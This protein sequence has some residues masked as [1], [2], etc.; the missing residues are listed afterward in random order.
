MEENRASVPTTV[1]LAQILSRGT[2]KGESH[3]SKGTVGPS[4]PIQLAPEDEWAAARR[5]DLFLLLSPPEWKQTVDWRGHKNSRENTNKFLCWLM[6]ASTEIKWKSIPT[7]W[8]PTHLSRSLYHRRILWLLVGVHSSTNIYQAPTIWQALLHMLE[9]H[10]LWRGRQD[11]LA[12]HN[13][14][15]RF[16]WNG[17]PLLEWH[18]GVNKYIDSYMWRNGYIK[19]IAV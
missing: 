13:K 11:I 6:L 9:I 4:L 19:M 16:E 14:N 8:L 2:G 10:I 17:R 3:R 1:I 7:T 12:G 18:P 15:S 5:A